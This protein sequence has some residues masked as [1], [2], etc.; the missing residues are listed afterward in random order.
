MPANEPDRLTSVSSAGE[1]FEI[2]CDESGFSGG[3]LVGNG[4]ARSSCTRACA[5]TRG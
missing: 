5:S 1:P 2:A 4:A 3:N